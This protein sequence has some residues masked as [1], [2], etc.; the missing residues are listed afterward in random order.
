MALVVRIKR[1]LNLK[2]GKTDVDPAILVS[3]NGEPLGETSVKRGTANPAWNEEFTFHSPATATAAASAAAPLHVEFTAVDCRGSSSSGSKP[4]AAGHAV[5][6]AALSVAAANLTGSAVLQLREAAR[7]DGQKKSSSSSAAASSSA[8]AAELHVSWSMEAREPEFRQTLEGLWAASPVLFAPLFELE[9]IVSWT[10]PYKSA[11]LLLCCSWL[12]THISYLFCAAALGAAS[13]LA[14]TFHALCRAGPGHDVFA[15]RL[16]ALVAGSSSAAAA[17]AAAAGG[18]EGKTM[19]VGSREKMAR[20]YSDRHLETMSEEELRLK[21]EFLHEV[22]E[23][24][25]G[26]VCDGL[27]ALWAVLTYESVDAANLVVEALL[28]WIVAEL[29]GLAPRLEHLVLA[30]V[31]AVFLAY[32][33]HKHFPTI[34]RSYNLLH[35]LFDDGQGTLRDAKASADRIVFAPE[36]HAAAPARATVSLEVPSNAALAYNEAERTTALAAGLRGLEAERAARAAA[37]KEVKGSPAR[38]LKDKRRLENG[39]DVEEGDSDNDKQNGGGRMNGKSVKGKGKDNGTTG[40]SAPWN[41][42]CV[43]ISKQEHREKTTHFKLEVFC[44]LRFV[45]TFFGFY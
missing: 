6:T 10:H 36:E 13:F 45:H 33:L 21:S 39:N 40:P 43:Y 27:D 4:A 26:R 20:L 19:P 35:F 3:V 38:G 30:G 17:A 18:G 8:P 23:V 44:Y 37:K 28:V 9:S 11:F 29:F 32:P 15:E 34:A 2:R 16:T 22:A 12:L 25:L 41:V 5:G 1:G 7:R 31:W 14:Y 42:L 24:R